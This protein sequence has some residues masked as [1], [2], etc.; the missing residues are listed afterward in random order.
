LHA[1]FYTIGRVEPFAVTQQF[2][3]KTAVRL[4]PYPN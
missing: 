2:A 3:A 1:G 4:R